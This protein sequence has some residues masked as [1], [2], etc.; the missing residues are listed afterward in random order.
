MHAASEFLS[1]QKVERGDNPVYFNDIRKQIEACE[2]L[3]TF[4]EIGPEYHTLYRNTAGDFDAKTFEK[5]K[6]DFYNGESVVHWNV[7]TQAKH[8]QLKNTNK[9]K[10]VFLQHN[11]FEEDFILELFEGCDVVYDT[12]MNRVIDDSV[13][14]YSN[15]SSTENVW[16]YSAE[17][18]QNLF[19]FQNKLRNYFEQYKNK[20]CILVHLGDEHCHAE[21]DYYKNFKH[22]F[23]QYHRKDASANNVTFIPLGYKKGFLK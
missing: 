14:V 22:V 6:A 8:T 23:R 11:L 1:G 4:R 17:I 10:L 3:E 7:E 16:K 19:D 13:I 21:I 20:N 9:Q 2:Y 12:E 5:D 18:A 15:G